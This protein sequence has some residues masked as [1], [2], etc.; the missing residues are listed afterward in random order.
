MVHASRGRRERDDGTTEEIEDASLLA[1]LR[2][3]A[4]GVW[5]RVWVATAVTSL[6]LLAA[7]HP[8]ATAAR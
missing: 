7:K 5:L 2:R 8:L 3:R 4:R 1:A 6:L